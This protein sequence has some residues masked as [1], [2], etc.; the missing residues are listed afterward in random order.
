MKKTVWRHPLAWMAAAVMLTGC[1]GFN[2][3][4]SNFNAESF[5]ADWIIT[6]YDM[7]GTPF[8]CWKLKGISVMNERDSDGIK[9]SESGHMMHISGWYNRVQVGNGDFKGA[10]ERLHID[11]DQCGNGRYP[12]NPPTITPP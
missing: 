5:G 3:S 1:A 4:C 8:M 10:G 2:T 11:A 7:N 9:W 12:A 6:E